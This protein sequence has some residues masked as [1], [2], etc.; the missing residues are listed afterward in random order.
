VVLTEFGAENK[1]NLP[2]GEENLEARCQWV[3]Y[4]LTKAKEFGVPCVQWD[5][6]IYNASGER[7]GLL[8]RRNLEWYEPDYIKAMMDAIAK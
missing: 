3:N 5:N 6:N 4:Y 8:D 2:G 7:F 1:T